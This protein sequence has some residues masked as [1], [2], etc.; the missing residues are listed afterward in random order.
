MTQFE[1]RI[2]DHPVEKLILERWSPRAFTGAPIDRETLMS[3]FEAARW[4]PSSYN[5]QP[6]RYIYAHRETPAWEKI[7][8]LLVAANQGWAKDAAVL[9]VA[10]SKKTMAPRGTEMPSYSHSFDAGAGWQNMAL[11]ATALG[12]HA[13]GMTGIDMERAATELGVPDGYRV[14]MAIAIGKQGDKA[15]LPEMFQGMEAPN[16]RNPVESFI[17]EGVFPPA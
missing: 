5:S 9:I 14:E 1:G 11:Q 17:F 2:S 8:S 10:V 4:A 12:W 3:I 13:H 15:S 16:G 7:F 6:W